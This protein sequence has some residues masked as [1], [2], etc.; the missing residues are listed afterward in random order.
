MSA[1]GRGPRLGGAH[2]VYATPSWTVRRLLESPLAQLP[3]GIWLDAGAGD[4][5]IIKAVR[6][7][8][9]DVTFAAVEIRASCRRAL[10]R[11]GLRHLDIA[12]LLRMR[13][14]DALGYRPVVVIGNPPYEHAMAFVVASRLV[15]P[16]AWIVFLLRLPFASSYDRAEFMIAN[17]PDVL[18]LP[19]RPSFANEG[20][21]NTDYAWFIW[22]P[23]AAFGCSY[24]RFA[25]LK[26]TSLLERQAG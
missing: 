24:G 22:P 15:A 8:R 21:D 26:T 14:E 11:L 5:A 6:G 23:P 2:D 25:V 20:T 13:S 16:Y 9:T 1:T 17:P 10:A 18:V 4:G 19:D 7:V 12:D 3:S